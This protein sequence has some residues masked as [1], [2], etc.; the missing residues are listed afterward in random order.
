MIEKIMSF[1]SRPKSE[2]EHETPEGYCPNCWGTQEYD[3][4]IREMYRDKQIDVNNHLANYAF[5]RDFVVR[6]I[7]GIRLKKGAGS[8]ECPT[9]KI[10]Y[11]EQGE[12]LNEHGKKQ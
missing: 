11:S 9:C 4:Q 7:D 8:L 3:Q 6:H 5:I 10:R 12:R 1:F 2:R